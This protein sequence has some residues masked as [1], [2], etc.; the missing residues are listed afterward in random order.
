[1]TKTQRAYFRAAK[2]VSELSDHPQH[3]HGCV[4]VKGHRIISSGYNSCIRQHRVQ[5]ELDMERFGVNCPGKLHS[6]TSALLPLIKNDI[7]LSK[8]SIYI[9]REHKNGALANSKPCPS[10]ERLIRQFGIKR[11]YYTVENGYAEVKY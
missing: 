9:Y 5:A 7:D 6:E 2:A 4:V 1:M 8:A 11:V 3:K 10:C